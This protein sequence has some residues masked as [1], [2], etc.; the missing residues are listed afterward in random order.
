MT[1]NFVPAKLA[2]VIRRK[3]FVYY[4]ISAL[5]ILRCAGLHIHVHNHADPLEDLRLEVVNLTNIDNHGDTH[6]QD[7]DIDVLGATLTKY[8]DSYLDDFVPLAILALVVL[9]LGGAGR[10]IPLPPV[11]AVRSVFRHQRP[12]SRAP[13][14]LIFKS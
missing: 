11:I 1:A 9:S 2:Y 3:F 7:I 8:A 5:V 4:I 14:R 10:I 12:P 6:T 13:P